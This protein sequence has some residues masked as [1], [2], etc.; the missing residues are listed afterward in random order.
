MPWTKKDGTRD[1]AKQNRLYDSKPKARQARAD[2]V[3]IQRDLEKSGRASKGDGMDNAHKRAY[4]KGGG[5]SLKNIKLQKPSQ[6]RS[7]KR[8][9]NGTMK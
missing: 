8:N 5:T 7:F 6:N 2:G 1:V 3:K 9:A 4:S